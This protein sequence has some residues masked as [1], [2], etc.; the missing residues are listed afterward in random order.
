MKWD[1][2]SREKGPQDMQFWVIP[3]YRSYT[4]P[5]SSRFTG[6]RRGGRDSLVDMLLKRLSPDPWI[7]KLK[8]GPSSLQNYG[9]CKALY[10]PSLQKLYDISIHFFSHERKAHV[11]K[12]KAGSIRPCRYCIIDSFDYL[13]LQSHHESF[14][15]D[16]AR[17]M[18]YRAAGFEYWIVP[19]ITPM[20]HF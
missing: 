14:K 13:F 16:K 15:T 3:L 11:H 8:K 6:L 10:T 5:P 18:K 17:T 4:C 20:Q 9:L 1:C 7:G 2:E 19:H 12:K